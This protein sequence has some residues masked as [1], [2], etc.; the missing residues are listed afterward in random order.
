MCT[1]VGVDESAQPS[2]HLMQGV[3]L[4]S[5]PPASNPLRRVFCCPKEPRFMTGNLP[6]WIQVLLGCATLLISIVSLKAARQR[7]E[8]RTVQT[9]FKLG[10][11]E[12]SRTEKTDIQS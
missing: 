12:Y 6:D 3:F 11:L 5:K 7:R 4:Y 9:S 1:P 10:R 2:H 8:R